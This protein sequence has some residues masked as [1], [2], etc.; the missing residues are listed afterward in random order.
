M[1]GAT[2]VWVEDSP[3]RIDVGVVD[4]A[5]DERR[6]DLSSCTGV[7]FEDVRARARLSHRREPRGP[8]PRTSRLRNHRHAR[9]VPGHDRLLQM[10]C[11]PRRP[12][13]RSGVPPRPRQGL[14]SSRRLVRRLRTTSSRRFGLPRNHR[15]AAP[16]RPASTRSY[17]SA[18]D[19]RPSS[20]EQRPP[21]LASLTSRYL[22]PLEASLAR[23]ADHQ[24]SARH[25]W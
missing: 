17:S 8:R 22:V 9:P 15:S 18:V 19:P 2:G 14:H 10:H 3:C 6:V 24:P 13:A 21:R 7:R 23:P 1:A 11:S 5:G 25:I 12:S 16:S 4:E 20:R